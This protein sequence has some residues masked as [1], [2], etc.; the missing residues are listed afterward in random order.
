MFRPSRPSRNGIPTQSPFLLHWAMFRS[1]L[2]ALLATIP[3]LAQPFRLAIPIEGERYRDWVLVNYV[4]HTPLSEGLVDHH[5]GAQT[6]KGHQG[7]DFVLRSFRQMD[8]GVRVL[9]AAPGRVTVA[10]DTLPDRNKTS[11]VERGYG[12][13]VTILHADGYT[14][15]YAHLRTGSATV[16]VGDSVVTGQTLGLVGSS[17]NSS[18]PHLHFEVWKNVDP[19]GGTCGDDPSLWTE[20]PEYRTDYRFLDGGV[21]T[22]PATLDTIRERPEDADIVTA[23]HP[24]VTFWSLQQG[25]RP[26]DVVT[27]TWYH[28]DGTVWFTIDHTAGV[29]SEYYYW[30]T[31][32]D[33]PTVNGTWTVVQR[34]NEVDVLRRSFV[35]AVT[36]SVIRPDG[37]PGTSVPS[38]RLRG[39][40]LAVDAGGQPATI[41]A[42]DM[43]GRRLQEFSATKD[44][45][46]TSLRPCVVRIVVGDRSVC[47]VVP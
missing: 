37:V 40:R 14:T 21:T 13:V 6:Y 16:H 5:C 24:T 19:F 41:T 8:A 17:G 23:D 4:D 10:V 46:L 31:Y 29:G 12:N 36:P 26:T 25:I 15:T 39:H 27:T 1:L 33:R 30:W 32:I 45:D 20:Q 35:V 34:V 38:V 18:D 3:T 7:T 44:I 9:A 47:Q 28:P 42:Y 43:G 2:V 11:V 22:W